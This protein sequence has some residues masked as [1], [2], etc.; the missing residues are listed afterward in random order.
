MPGT[1]LGALL[2]GDGPPSRQPVETKTNYAW[3]RFLVLVIFGAFFCSQALAQ[4]KRPDEAAPAPSAPLKQPWA[5]KGPPPTLPPGGVKLDQK[6][7]RTWQIGIKVKAV[8]GD[9]ASVVGTIPIPLEWPEQTVKLLKQEVD[10]DVRIE[11]RSVDPG[12][13]QM[14]VRFPKIIE[15]TELQAVLTLEVTKY[16]LAAPDDPSRFRIPKKVPGPV[17]KYLG[18]S[19]LIETQNG[20]LR[21]F[22]KEALA[23]AKPADGELTGW[24]T[25]ETLF[26]AVRARVK[27][28]AQQEMGAAA[29]FKNGLA[30]REDLNAI[31]VAACRIAKIP[32]RMV[33]VSDNCY[34]EFFLE[35]ETGQGHW[36]PAHVSRIDREIGY[37]SSQ[38]AILEKGDNFKV[39]ER[40]EPL[41]FVPEFLRGSSAEGG[42]P[43]VV[44]VRKLEKI[45]YD[46]G[47]AIPEEAPEETPDDPAS[48]ES[49]KE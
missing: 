19:P 21:T 32:A 14:V 5:T 43:K 47:E 42:K 7:T 20:T 41:R 18:P 27:L 44:F 24:K 40:K 25:A 22:V 39:Y 10:E 38:S 12:I 37:V 15:D 16:S 31:F 45:A 48:E 49:S 3:H 26:D 23:E 30:E 33:W 1:V 46:D 34:T 9:V 35:D 11:Y 17:T 4:D 13:R 8:G 6:L 2:L 29:A 36:L 28:D